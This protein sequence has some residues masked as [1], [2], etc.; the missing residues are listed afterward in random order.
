[1]KWMSVFLL[2]LMYVIIGPLLFFIES[3]WMPGF[4]VAEV[5]S[6]IWGM[7]V[8]FFIFSWAELML[9]E[10]YRRTQ[11]GALT[12]LYLA[13]KGLRFFLA[14]MAVVVYG[15]LGGSSILLFSI[16][17]VVFYLATMVFMTIQTVRGE[18]KQ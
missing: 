15:V 7:G 5:V 12:G 16:N 10:R 14:F 2:A 9:T 6:C 11:P 3:K 8:V 13:F 17:I 18:Q 4:N 1:M